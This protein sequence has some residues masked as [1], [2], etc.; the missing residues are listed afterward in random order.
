[1]PE[2]IRSRKRRLLLSSFEVGS[3][4]S[5]RTALAR[6]DGFLERSGGTVSPGD[7]ILLQAEIEEFKGVIVSLQQQLD[8]FRYA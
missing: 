1:M 2:R 4:R 8:K 5:K 6:A 3:P 7:D